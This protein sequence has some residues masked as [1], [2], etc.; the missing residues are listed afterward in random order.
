MQRDTA[1]TI[2]KVVAVLEWVGAAFGILLALLFMLG[3]PLIAQT[4]LAQM[5]QEDLGMMAASDMLSYLQ[6]GLIV[7]GVFLLL[8]CG[9]GILTGIGLWRL[10]NWGRILELISS[11]FAGIW[12][13]FGILGSFGGSTTDV[14][15]GV[16][17]NGLMVAISA[18]FIW[19]FQFEPTVVGLFKPGPATTVVTKR[20]TSKKKR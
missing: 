17:V 4:V 16:F 20:S 5:P 3:G 19:L 18:V 9:L 6:L 2:V 13:I 12:G 10:R 1:L 7:F 15:F 14:L 8:L 11:W